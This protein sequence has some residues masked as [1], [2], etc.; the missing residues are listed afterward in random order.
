MSRTD[1]SRFVKPRT[2][3]DGNMSR[4]INA[5]NLTSTI[6]PY[7]RR[8]CPLPYVAQHVIKPKTVGSK[9]FNCCSLP[10]VPVTAAA[11]TVGK[12][13]TNLLASVT[14]RHSPCTHRIFPFRFGRLAEL[15]FRAAIEFLDELLHI[16]P[17]YFLN[18]PIITLKIGGGFVP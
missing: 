15:L 7:V 1:E 14:D 2:A 10:V 13:P 12:V 6:R 9:A 11:I 5:P 18:G 8:A 4:L 16:V 3:T 17:V